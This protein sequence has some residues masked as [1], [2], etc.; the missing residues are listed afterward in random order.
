MVGGRLVGLA[1][2]AEQAYALEFI[3]G[4]EIMAGWALVAKPEELAERISAGDI[5]KSLPSAL[6][7]ATLLRPRT[8]R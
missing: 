1:R 3:E 2:Q 4:D 6:A 7:Q 5:P 8:L